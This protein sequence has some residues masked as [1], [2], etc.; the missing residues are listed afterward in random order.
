MMGKQFHGKE[1]HDQL[2]NKALVLWD[3]PCTSGSYSANT[4]FEGQC[5]CHVNVNI[6]SDLEAIPKV[7]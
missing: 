5:C 4:M 3:E 7:D 6:S 2:F 1:P